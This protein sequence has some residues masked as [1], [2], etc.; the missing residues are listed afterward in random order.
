MDP[1]EELL[2][3]ARHAP[4]ATTENLDVVRRRVRRRTATRVALASG[5]LAAIAAGAVVAVTMQPP[6]RTLRPAQVPLATSSPASAAVTPDPEL[7]VVGTIGWN[8]VTVTEDGRTLR[9]DYAARSPEGGRGPCAQTVRARLDERA[10]AVTVTLEVV[11]PADEP[12]PT[13]CTARRYDRTAVV[14]LEAPLRDRRVVDG[15]NGRERPVER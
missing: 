10:D 2:R 8:G 14:A 5:G 15:S 3:S 9:V 11:A 4:A 13:F 12:A 1:L 6:T 7:I